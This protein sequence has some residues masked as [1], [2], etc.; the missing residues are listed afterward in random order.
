MPEAIPVIQSTV[1]ERLQQSGIFLM[2]AVCSWND[3][4]QQTS[5][6]NVVVVVVDCIYERYVF[7]HSVAMSSAGCSCCSPSSLD[8]GQLLTICDIVWCLP[9]GHM[10]VAARPPLLSLSGLG[11]PGSDSGDKN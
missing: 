2:P 3:F 4:S 11:W 5:P 6:S 7:S 9:Q 10:S 1:S 8:C